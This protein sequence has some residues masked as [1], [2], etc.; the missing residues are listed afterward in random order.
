[1]DFFLPILIGTS[2]LLAVFAAL[3]AANTARAHGKRPSGERDAQRISVLFF[4]AADAFSAHASPEGGVRA[5]KD[6]L[7]FLKKRYGRRRARFW[8]RGGFAAV[9]EREEDCL[10]ELGFCRNYLEQRLGIKIYAG[11][12]RSRNVRAKGFEELAEL[13]RFAATKAKKQGLDFLECG[14]ELE[15]EKADADELYRDFE[16]SLEKDEFRPFF[17][18]VIDAVS[19]KVPG[20]SAV[21]VLNKDVYREILPDKFLPIACEK[22]LLSVV[23]KRVLNK[24]LDCLRDWIDRGL[25]PESF[26]VEIALSEETLEELDADEIKDMLSLRGL[27]PENLLISSGDLENLPRLSEKLFGLELAAECGSPCP[28]PGAMPALR[29]INVW[30]LE[31]LEFQAPEIE[32]FLENGIS[33]LAKGIKSK[34]GFD[35]ARELKF[36][37]LCG[38]FFSRLEGREKFELF[39]TKYKEGIPL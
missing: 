30:G 36:P 23:E 11:F 14:P 3:V 35:A 8:G 34:R 24:C 22:G 38:P 13:A 32:R 15:I 18:P 20:C 1:M 26:F 4:E 2:C 17:F 7:R 12:V 37:L 25:V 31:E 28:D 16:S 21:S 10:E 9:L 33:L 29:H 6:A 27:S 39:L 19:L 5:L